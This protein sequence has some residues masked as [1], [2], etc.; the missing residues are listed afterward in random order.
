LRDILRNRSNVLIINNLQQKSTMKST[1]FLCLLTILFSCTAQTDIT[2]VKSD[3]P[4]LDFSK[5]QYVNEFQYDG[6]FTITNEKNSAYYA[7][8]SFNG[9][10]AKAIKLANEKFPVENGIWF[11]ERL[12][13]I[14]GPII[15][16]NS[17]IGGTVAINDYQFYRGPVSLGNSLKSFAPIKFNADNGLTWKVLDIGLFDNSDFKTRQNLSAADKSSFL[18]SK[19][20]I[21][22]F[23]DV[24]K[25]QEKYSLSSAD[26]DIIIKF[27]TPQ[28]ADM[29]YFQFDRGNVY[30]IGID[31]GYY[32]SYG[33][34]KYVKGNANQITILRSELQNFVA[35]AKEIAVTVTAIKFYTEKS[36]V[37]N[38][39]YKNAAVTTSKI[40]L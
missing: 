5:A 2:P 18:M 37:R 4:D 3:A 15:K 21:T 10:E 39:L 35:N 12:S 27:D 25:L 33:F 40:N 23:P 13:F 17:G 14:I 38:F 29:I 24:V 9:A 28:N 31:Y 11:D 7:S 22:L 6:V 20:G 36:G 34:I 26:K 19:S 8:Y 30:D 16:Y 1:L 32:K